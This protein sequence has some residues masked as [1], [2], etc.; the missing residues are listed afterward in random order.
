MKLR[1]ATAIIVI[2]E[3]KVFFEVVGVLKIHA[4]KV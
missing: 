2:Q 3:A 1:A 4:A